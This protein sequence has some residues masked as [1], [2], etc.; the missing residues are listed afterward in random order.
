MNQT[1]LSSSFDRNFGIH[2]T[3]SI[4]SFSESSRIRLPI[5]LSSVSPYIP[6]PL[7]PHRVLT[8][9]SPYTLIESLHTL[10]LYPHRVLTY[11]STLISLHTTLL[12]YPSS[13]SPCLRCITDHRQCPACPKKSWRPSGLPNSTLDW[14]FW[15]RTL[16]A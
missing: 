4:P 9:H 3:P 1:R 14:V 7:Y 12:L 6:L 15:A 10:P 2:H 16:R 8:Y 13:L 5:Y 11:H